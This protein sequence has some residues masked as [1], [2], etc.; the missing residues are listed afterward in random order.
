MTFLPT[1]QL[2]HFLSVDGIEAVW[3]D[4]H[5]EQPRVGLV[6]GISNI[7]MR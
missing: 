5:T 4:H 1:V 3:V 2:N 7:R 6:E